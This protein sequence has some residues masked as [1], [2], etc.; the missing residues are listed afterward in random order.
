M[1]PKPK[2][3]RRVIED[4]IYFENL[5]RGINL[6]NRT[7]TLS[8]EIDHKTFLKVDAALS[9]FESVN[10]KPITVKIN[11]PGGNV[12]DALAIV[13]RLKRSKCPI[14]TEGY[15]AVMSAATLILASGNTRRISKLAW[16][17]HHET[18]YEASGKHSEHKALVAQL[19]REDTQWANWMAS[20]TKC[21]AE[22]WKT[23]G[24]GTDAYFTP[25]QLLQ[26]GVVDVII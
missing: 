12:Y 9:E 22:F 17:L 10:S 13:G 5:F 26:F 4:D 8:D 24:K 25:D 23:T 6:K 2:A 16:F 19:D 3:K 11:S 1:T 20:F 7:I 18:D 21:D 15:G 14:I